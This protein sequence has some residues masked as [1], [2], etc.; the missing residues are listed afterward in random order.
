MDAHVLSYLVP[1]TQKHNTTVNTIHSYMFLLY[2]TIH[3]GFPLLVT[4]HVTQLVAT[5]PQLQHLLFSR[6]SS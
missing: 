4:V 5:S 3:H 2:H 1:L 6:N